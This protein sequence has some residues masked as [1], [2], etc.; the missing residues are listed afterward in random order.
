MT[1][2]PDLGTNTMVASGAQIRAVGWLSDKRPFRT[3]APGADVIARLKE[4]VSLHRATHSSILWQEMY[5]MGGHRCELCN[6]GFSVACIAIPAD[7]ALFV[8]PDMVVHYIEAHDYSPPA[9]FI[10]AL[11]SAPLPGTTEYEA[12]VLALFDEDHA[13]HVAE[14][15]RSLEESRIE[16]GRT[17][18]GRMVFG[19]F[20]SD[21][22]VASLPRHRVVG[23]LLRILALACVAAAGAFTIVKLRHR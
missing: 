3:G 13:R 23:R 10:E 8:A 19:P 21:G 12:A 14:T 2:F 5:W 1:W 9:E 18:D 11:M 17:S 20:P 16:S 15:R 6:T 7:R 22:D 4:V